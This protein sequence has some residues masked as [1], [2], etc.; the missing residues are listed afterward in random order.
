MHQSEC[1]FKFGGDV[2]IKILVGSH[3][4]STDAEIPLAEYVEGSISLEF[5]DS[6]SGH[7][8]EGWEGWSRMD[9]IIISGE[10]NTTTYSR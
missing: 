9:S 3:R 1:R 7:I 4:L 6:F 10:N 5:T 2:D 8:T